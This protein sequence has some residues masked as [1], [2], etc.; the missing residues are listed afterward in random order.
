MCILDCGI[1]RKGYKFTG[2]LIGVFRFGALTQL[3]KRLLLYARYKRKGKTD[4]FIQE[5][6][7]LVHSRNEPL[8]KNNN[9]QYLR[10]WQGL[11]ELNLLY[12]A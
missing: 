10:D 1:K 7:M 9:N 11:K 12:H 5:T 6:T 4:V 2:L 8:G 3:T